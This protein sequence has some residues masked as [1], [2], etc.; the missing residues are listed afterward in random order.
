MVPV[1][2]Q[3]AVV[4]AYMREF[5]KARAIFDQLEHFRGASPERDAELKNQRELIDAIEQG[6]VRLR[7]PPPGPGYT[8]LIQAIERSLAT[9]RRNDTCVCGS[10][11]KFK[12][13]CG[14]A[15]FQPLAQL[16]LPRPV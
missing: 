1:Q 9:R 3:Y 13:C 6:V 2:A 8:S 4:L 5:D 10:S 7:M 14:R 12:K 11:L 16:L 15:A